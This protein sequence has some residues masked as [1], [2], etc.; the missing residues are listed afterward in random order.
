MGL[1]LIETDFLPHAEAI[2]ES[3]RSEL[4]IST[5]KLQLSDKS[6]GDRIS[7]LF[8]R[9]IE[10][11][12]EGVKVKVLLNWHPNRR[13]VARTNYPAAKYL[14]QHGIEVRHLKDNRCCHAKIFCADKK[15][16]IVGSHNLSIKSCAENFEVSYLIQNEDE[17]AAISRRFLSSF[18]GAEKI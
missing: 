2:T 15:Q 14:Q 10:K 11:A 8:R 18:N 17:A 5:F 7:R 13:C 1:V 9:L 6:A 3:A 12:K 16:V 4:L